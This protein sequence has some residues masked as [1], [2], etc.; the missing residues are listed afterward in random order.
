M[1]VAFVANVGSRDIQVVDAASPPK[2]SRTL[3]ELILKDWDTMRTKIRMPILV[4]ALEAVLKKHQQI[5]QIMLFATDQTDGQ[6]RHTDTYP[7][8]QVIQRYLA[9]NYDAA[10]Q[11]RYGETLSSRVTIEPIAANPADYDQMMHYYGGA[12]AKLDDFPTVYLEVTGGTPAMSFMLLWQGVEVLRQRAHPLY[13]L[14]ERS[15]PVS[16]NIAQT[17]T[18]D[19]LRDDVLDSVR[20][21][22][23]FA[24]QKLLDRNLPFLQ[25]HLRHIN[26]AYALVRYANHRYNFNFEEAEGVL[27]GAEV[28]LP[29]DWAEA[30]SALAEEVAARNPHWLLQEELYGIEV[31]LRV[32]A[33]KD[34]L[35][36][37]FAFL[38]G[39]LREV[40]SAR[41]VRLTPDNRMLDPDWLQTVPDL[42]AYL[43]RKNI[44]LSRTVTTFVFERALGFMAKTDPALA[45]L[46]AR[47]QAFDALKKA[48]NDAIHH[49]R[50]MS[51][52][53]IGALYNGG[54]A[55]LLADLQ[56]LYRDA[57]GAGA[58]PNPYDRVNALVTALLEPAP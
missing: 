42:Q 53:M 22:Q 43:E 19:A 39:L 38:E 3:G 15:L 26:A 29:P 27:L 51:E 10:Y 41:G 5:D 40:A 24:A 35:A 36:N 4:K 14:Q 49:H 48:R 56:Q 20:A 7:F 16:L 54:T 17:L 21:H 37:I 8:A 55:L 32:G 45:D 11:Q 30:V 52:E 57:L 28:G 1:T 25:R 44:D 13:V 47:I 34:A 2:D 18:L 23:Y 31:D 46:Q 58:A 33:Y 50:G 9:E 6:Y 12:L